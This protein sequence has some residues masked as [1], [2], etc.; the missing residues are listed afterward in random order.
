MSTMN[1]D[2][3]VG[4]AN[5]VTCPQCGQLL[6]DASRVCG[7]CGFKPAETSGR[8][9]SGELPLGA[10]IGGAALVITAALAL[11]GFALGDR[12]LGPINPIAPAA[13]D[14]WVGSSLLRGSRKLLGFAKFR[15]IAGAVVYGVIFLGKGG[16]TTAILQVVFSLALCGLLFG[17]AGKV[18]IGVATAA[19]A[20]LVLLSLLGLQ[21]TLT[22]HNLLS[23]AVQQIRF[24]LH[25]AGPAPVRGAVPGYAIGP[26][27]SR[28]KL[29][30]RE[31]A[32]ETNAAADLWFIDTAH[33]AAIMV[34][35]EAP[36]NLDQW[37]LD[38]L[39]EVVVGHLEK[40]STNVKKLAERTRTLHGHPVRLLD[41][42]TTMKGLELRYKF[43]L[44]VQ[45]GLLIQV[46]CFSSKKAFPILED[47]FQKAIES[48][49]TEPPAHPPSAKSA[50]P[51][52]TVAWLATAP[53]S[54]TL[55]IGGP[56]RPPTV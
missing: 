44:F 5:W 7:H 4:A 11:L 30:D 10:R 17:K 41:I 3:T 19:T 36:P 35:P 49:V 29:M 2:S 21:Q 37:T 43:G 23:A 32:R 46:L 33:D 26:F 15:V 9:G 13:I 54:L 50:P 14:V 22:G 42:G 47:D 8:G 45:D 6:D 39:Q 52:A 16:P 12:D 48:L 27:P 40:N 56:G 1:T 25:P 20:I 28:W 55:E 34:I 38:R 53:P 31:Q 51:G 24:R 18:R